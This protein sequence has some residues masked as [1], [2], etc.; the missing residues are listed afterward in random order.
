MSRSGRT[1]VAD[2]TLN[3]DLRKSGLDH[4][5]DA[6]SEFGYRPMLFGRAVL[7]LILCRR[8]RLEQRESFHGQVPA[9]LAEFAPLA[10]GVAA[11]PIEIF[12]MSSNDFR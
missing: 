8:A 10:G 3:P 7:G 6:R 11:G 9:A 2:L 1:V 12:F 4:A 5:F